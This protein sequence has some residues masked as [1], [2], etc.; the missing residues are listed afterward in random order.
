MTELTITAKEVLQEL[1]DN[2]KKSIEEAEERRK[3][4]SA[5]WELYKIEYSDGEKHA[6]ED[7]AKKLKAVL[8]KL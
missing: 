1:I 5:K 6:Y 2:F 8:D 4:A 3:A 7:A